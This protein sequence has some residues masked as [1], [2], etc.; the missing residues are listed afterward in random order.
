LG[1]IRV[2]SQ[3]GVG[4]GALNGHGYA[5]VGLAWAANWYAVKAWASRSL[6][7]ARWLE[8]GPGESWFVWCCIL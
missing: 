7:Q 3:G 2:Q 4:G 5:K 1:R 6:R 8:R